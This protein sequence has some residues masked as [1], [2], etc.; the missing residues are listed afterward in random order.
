MSMPNNFNHFT[1]KKKKFSK[2][3]RKKRIKVKRQ[4]RNKYRK[5][6]TPP[7]YMVTFINGLNVGNQLALFYC[8]DKIEAGSQIKRAH[9]GKIRLERKVDETNSSNNTIE[10]NTV[11]NGYIDMVSSRIN[12]IKFP[13]LGAYELI[14][15]GFTDK[16]DIARVD[17]MDNKK[18]DN[19]F[20]N[21]HLFATYPFEVVL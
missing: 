15:Y 13:G 12:G 7:F 2:R 5:D 11:E 9:A 1:G 16:T 4:H 17:Q 20:T 8:I 21:E 19:E 18:R 6:V 14:V 3:R 10:N